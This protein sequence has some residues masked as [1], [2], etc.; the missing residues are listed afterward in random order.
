LRKGERA[1]DAVEKARQIAQ[2]ASDAKAEDIVLLDV[3]AVSSIT[4]YFV[5]ATGLSPNH[6]RA[7]ARQVEDAMR[8][9]GMKPAHVDGMQANGW[10]VLDYGNVIVHAMLAD[11]RRYYDVERLW[12]DAPRTEWSEAAAAAT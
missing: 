8:T 1:I 5:F 4:D 3:A 10:L 12:G 9:Q 2:I 7:V 6:L 11:V